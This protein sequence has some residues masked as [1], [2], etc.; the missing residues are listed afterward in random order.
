MRVDL[1][2][3]TAALLAFPL[4]T[5]CDPLNVLVAPNLL[6]VGTPENVF[7]EA[8]DYSGNNFPVKISVRNHPQKTSELT[9]K[10]VVLTAENKYQAVVDIKIPDNKN[11]FSDDPLEKQ[12]VYL[13][14]HFPSGVLEKVVLLSFQSGYIFVQTDK[15]IYTPGTPVARYKNTPQTNFTAEFEVKEYV[16]PSFEVALIPSKSFFYV[17]DNELQVDISAKYLF[18]K[19]VEGVAFVVFGVMRDDTKTT[20]TA[21]LKREPI[22][23]GEGRAVLTRE[24]IQHSFPNIADLVGS[25]LY[26]SV[27]VLTE[28]GSEMVEA[29]RR[30][31]QIVTSPYTIHFKRTPQFFKPGMSFDVT[32]YVTNP[33]QSPAE[34]VDVL[35][36]PGDV[37]GRTKSNGMAK[38]I[39]NSQ[40]GTSTLEITAKTA[41]RDISDKRQAENK[42]TAQAYTTK[43]GSSNYLHISVDAAELEIDD[44]INIDLNFGQSRVINQDFT[45]LILSK[46][47]IVEGKR[48]KRQEQSLVTLSLPVT[49]DLVPSFRVVAYYHIGS[50]EVVSDSIWVDVKDTCMGTLKLD[51]KESLNVKKIFEPRDEFHL[52]VTGDP[53]AKVGL[54]AVDKAVFVL[55]KNRLTQTKVWDIIEK[56]DTGCTAGSG[57]DSMGVF[58]DAGL[59][60]QSDKAGGTDERTVAPLRWGLEEAIRM[61][62]CQEPDPGGGPPGKLYVPLTI[63]PQALSWGH[64]SPFAGHPGVTRTL[65]FLRRRFWWPNMKKD[66]RA[67]VAACQ[68]CARNKEPHIRPSGLLH[69]L[70]IP[71]RPWSHLS[72]DFVTAKETAKL[73]LQHM[74]RVHGFPTDLVSDHPETNGQT[75]RVNQ[76][77]EH[78]LRCLASSNPSSWAEHLMWVEYAHNTL[79][80]S[81]IGMSPF[82]RQFGYPPPLFAEQE[83]EVGVPARNTWCTDAAE[84]GRKPNYL[85]KLLPREVPVQPIRKGVQAQPFVQVSGCGW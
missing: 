23:N 10:S 37:R 36:K 18:G 25:S 32:V 46:G 44:Q 6:R 80:H 71:S 15:S 58:Y 73:L 74:V 70:S 40:G 83:Q 78:S 12:Y 8:Q 62:F 72:L 53:T 51:V 9:S 79:W 67:Y 84:S 31:L 11:F 82:E 17:D 24:M 20:L 43:R 19:S 34:N 81:S 38:V 85:C 26:I 13:Q 48:F 49:K 56:H 76:D 22:I 14:A 42:M 77:L 41:A 75:E 29:E 50:S 5:L 16:L 45:Y 1:V 30:G 63:W 66:V 54:V 69:P 28:T 52:I 60:F 3:L 7:V 64:T 27:S 33:D 61:A 65:E 2:W 47:Q 35:V 57:K 39:V 59:L 68:I 4:L 21:S 55:N